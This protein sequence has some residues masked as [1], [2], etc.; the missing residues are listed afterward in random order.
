MRKSSLTLIFCVADGEGWID[1]EPA[2]SGGF[3]IGDEN[4][5]V[6]TV[7]AK[8]ADYT[9]NL[10]LLSRDIFP[11]KTAHIVKIILGGNCLRHSSE[12]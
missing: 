3:T 10:L 4:I 2:P 12:V 11:R 6:H 8:D 9:G 1:R 7:S 5:I